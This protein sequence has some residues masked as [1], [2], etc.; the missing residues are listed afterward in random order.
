MSALTVAIVQSELQWHDAA[1]NRRHFAEVADSID[2]DT[3]LIV[4]PEMF[5]TGFSMD[6][7]SLAEPMDGPTLAWMQE[8]AT[9]KNASVCGSV[10]IEDGGNYFNRFVSVSAGGIQVIYDKRHLFR[11][12]D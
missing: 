3:D 2:V 6:A 7:E 4:L 10:I 9:R 8:L 5:T 12:A 11:L 1:A